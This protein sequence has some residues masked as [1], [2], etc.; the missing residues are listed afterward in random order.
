MAKAKLT[1]CADELPPLGVKVFG[2]T[3]RPTPMNTE[4]IF[5]AF[6]AAGFNAA[7]AAGFIQSGE[8]FPAKVLAALEKAGHKQEYTRSA[9]VEMYRVDANER[10]QGQHLT[11]DGWAC[12]AFPLSGEFDL[13]P[14]HWTLAP[15]FTLGE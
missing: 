10:A 8:P 6:A 3:V 2:C 1:A 4:A 14:T 7:A 5:K 11:P 12:D 15:E 9:L 13:L